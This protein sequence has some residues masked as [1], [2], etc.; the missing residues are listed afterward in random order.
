MPFLSQ[1]RGRVRGLSTTLFWIP[2]DVFLGALHLE[3]AQCH[4][5]EATFQRFYWAISNLPSSFTLLIVTKYCKEH[6]PSVTC[7]WGHLSAHKSALVQGRLKWQ[8]CT[9]WTKDSWDLEFS[10]LPFFYLSI[11]FWLFLSTLLYFRKTTI[12]LEIY[13]QKLLDIEYI[14]GIHHSIY[15]NKHRV[16]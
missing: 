10:I 4:S 5:H 2:H 8:R 11:E 9:Q 15:S 13:H 1:I 6:W 16:Y 14:Y 12:A 7:W 3:D